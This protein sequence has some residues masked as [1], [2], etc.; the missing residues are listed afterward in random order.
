MLSKT[1]YSKN[2]RVNYIHHLNAFFNRCDA[3]P[4]LGPAHLSLYM[5]LF[6]LWNLN[7]FRNPVM[8]GRQTIMSLCKV[9]SPSTYHKLM[10]NLHDFAYIR[11]HPSH[12]SFK[13]SK[14]D[15]IPFD[16]DVTYPM[17]DTRPKG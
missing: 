2:P 17:Q 1:M 4:R 16:G 13:F 10:R 11:Y 7:H 8:T 5:A 14:I 3:D 9:G 15:M 6:R 12:H